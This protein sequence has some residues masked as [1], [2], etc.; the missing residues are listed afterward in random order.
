MFCESEAE[1]FADPARELIFEVG[2]AYLE[3]R[4]ITAA[5]LVFDPA[6][7]Q[8][9]L[10][11]GAR[12]QELLQRVALLQGQHTRRPV[13]ER[14][15]ELTALAEAAMKRVEAQAAALP[16]LPSLQDAAGRGL[17]TGTNLDEWVR[18]GVAF[19]RLLKVQDSLAAQAGFCLD[20]IEAGIEGEVRSM[21][22]QTLS[23]ILR[24]KPAAAS[25]YGD[26]VN[27]RTMIELC[28][29]LL[30]AK[31]SA[32]TAMTPIMTRLQQTGGLA[33]LPL[34][35]A[36]LRIRLTEMLN[37][38]AALFDPDPKGEWEA[39]LALKRRIAAVEML[40]GDEQLATVLD[41]RLSRFS[42]PDLLNPMLA[43]ESELARKLLL[44]LRFHREIAD[45]AARFELLG[46]IGHYLDA[47]DF[48]TAF[49]SPK[50]TREDFAEL[51]AAISAE[52]MQAEIPPAR[53]SAYL[54]LFRD[55]LATVVKPVGS[56]AGQRG[57]GGPEDHVLMRDMR[58]QLRNWSPAGLM[59]GPSNTTPEV[60]ARLP[61][62]VVVRNPGFSIEFSARAEILRVAD[63][64]I[65]ARYQCDDPAAAQR[66]KNYFA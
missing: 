44:L 31:P 63:G 62:T 57:Q 13:S 8:A 26:D 21:A 19:V 9:L 32:H 50:S 53:K 27:R 1:A 33:G 2:R 42:T 30:E 46:I 24:L 15:K 47:R 59:F 40:T 4:G 49:V 51:A 43:K 17:L 12:F 22:D 61:L 29:S 48:K 18:A 11:D 36:A 52:L 45:P 28:L 66:I 55:K 23:E 38:T 3:R 5:E 65:A 16:V 6:Q 56:R 37:G 58:L 60:G 41:R 25:I 14:M 35:R 54:Q 64:M 10:N 20:V 34:A 7:H 39:L